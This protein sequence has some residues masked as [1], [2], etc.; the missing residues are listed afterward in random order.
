MKGMLMMALLAMGCGDY[1]R[2]TRE[3]PCMVACSYVTVKSH[4]DAGKRIVDASTNLI[5]I[6]AADIGEVI[7]L[8][9]LNASMLIS[10]SRTWTEANDVLYSSPKSNLYY[11]DPWNIVC[12]EDAKTMAERVSNCKY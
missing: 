5:Y 8:Q 12:A 9:E 2:V 6:N 10:L 11:V 3:A 4:D 7:P 1:S